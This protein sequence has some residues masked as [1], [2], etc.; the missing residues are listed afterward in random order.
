M[1][2]YLIC[3][4]YVK[5]VFKPF[6]SIY[7]P[8]AYVTACR[9]TSRCPAGSTYLYS[10]NTF[11]VMDPPWNWKNTLPASR[12]GKTLSSNHKYLS[13]R[14]MNA[15]GFTITYTLNNFQMI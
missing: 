14:K 3:Q 9:S 7:R 15:H 13:G 8:Q 6:H 12:V 2:Y 5:T 10:Q 11:N 4:V 1:A